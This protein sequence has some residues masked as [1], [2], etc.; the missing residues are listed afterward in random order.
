MDNLTAYRLG[1]RA[2]PLVFHLGERGV[3]L[4]ESSVVLHS[5]TLFSALCLAWRS[6]G[7]D[8][9]Q[10]LSAFP[11]AGA[12]AAAPPPFL[13]SSGFPYSGGTYFLPRPLLRLDGIPDDPVVAKTLKK[14]V[15]VSQTLFER[16]IHNQ[17]VG[18]HLLR[19]VS[20]GKELRRDLLLQ[21]GKAWLTDSEA[22]ANLP[23]DRVIWREA[24]QPRVT[25]G[26][27]DSRS[28]P[29]GAGRV[30]FSEGCGLYFLVRYNDPVW[31]KLVEDALNVLA[32]EGIG[33]E[34]STGNGQFA[35]TAEAHFGLDEPET[36]EGYTSLSLLWPD[37]NSVAD[38][39][40]QGAQYSLVPRRGWIASPGAMALR[41]PNVRMLG[42]GS[43]F[44]RRPAG[45]LVD[46]TPMGKDN[47]ALLDHKV[48]RSGLAFPVA[49]RL[50]EE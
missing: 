15:Y 34:R 24:T 12:A 28:T 42:E 31:K 37:A 39:L 22:G 10:L 30:H 40:L 5:D 11:R 48:W 20:G 19:D 2:A 21:S 38:G 35:W 49:C 25:V 29:F 4:E 50:P 32:L 43:V 7:K 6:L 16:L 36:H 33:G 8:L 26:R 47:R 44:R 1:A 46:L 9:G 14:L 17:P 27:V 41:R 18:S 13:L 23:K 3:G 45:S